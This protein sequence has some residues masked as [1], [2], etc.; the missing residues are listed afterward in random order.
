MGLDQLRNDPHASSA[1]LDD[2]T[3]EYFDSLDLGLPEFYGMTEAT[4]PI[5]TN[6]P[7]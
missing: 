6:M 3:A 1:P 7:G 2:A 5:T 4:G